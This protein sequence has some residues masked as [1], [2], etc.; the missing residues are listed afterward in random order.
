MSGQKRAAVSTSKEG[1]PPKVTV[2]TVEKW[3]RDSDKA[4]DTSLWL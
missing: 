2:K 1:S 3:I 4:L